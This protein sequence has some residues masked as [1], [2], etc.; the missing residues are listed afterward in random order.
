M[1]VM[2]RRELRTHTF[3]LLFLTLFHPL[4]DMEEQKQLFFESAEVELDM[5]DT[6]YVQNKVQE[7][8]KRLSE[9]DAEIDAAA[10][11]WKVNRMNYVDLTLIRQAYYEMK[12]EDDVPTAVAINEAVEL[13]KIYGGEESSSFVNGILAKLL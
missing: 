8:I 12:Y 6:E 3:K 7:I 9:I 1:V 10:E 2:T 11:G 13:A 5:H 4:E